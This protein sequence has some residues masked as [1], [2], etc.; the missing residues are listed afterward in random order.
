MYNLITDEKKVNNP[1]GFKIRNKSN[2]DEDK[3]PYFPIQLELKA[4]KSHQQQLLMDKNKYVEHIK[5]SSS[6]KI[7]SKISPNTQSFT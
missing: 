5:S 6:F 3:K 7:G 1:E 4:D 2:T